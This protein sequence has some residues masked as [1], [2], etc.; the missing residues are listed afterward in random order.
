[1]LIK[2][3][4]LVV[5]IDHDLISQIFTWK[6]CPANTLPRPA[7]TIRDLYN[8]AIVIRERD[9]YHEIHNFLRDSINGLDIAC[10]YSTS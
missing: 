3:R 10:P 4:K 7:D 8:R 1:M 2:L 6:S 9:F 5:S